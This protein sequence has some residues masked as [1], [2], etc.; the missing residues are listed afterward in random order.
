MTVSVDGPGTTING[1]VITAAP[2]AVIVGQSTYRLANSPATPAN[3]A[4]TMVTGGQIFTAMQSG[5]SIYIAQG[6]STATVAE[7]SSATLDGQTIVAGSN[8][9]TMGSSTATFSSMDA[10]ATSDSEE[11]IITGVSGQKFTA[12][13]VSGN[14]IAVADGVT[15][16]AGGAGAHIEGQSVSLASNNVVVDGTTHGLSYAASQ[17]SAAGFA[18]SGSEMTAAITSSSGSSV[19]SNSASSETSRRMTTTSSET[20]E[21]PLKA[22]TT[23]ASNSLSLQGRALGLATLILAMW[24]LRPWLA[25]LLFI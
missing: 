2:S 22:T 25:M 7:V 13:I 19:V 1:E 21:K 3:K 18:T 8:G 6:G 10:S 5:I 4:A 23:S 12:R 24:I 11:A 16:T 20:S 9:I 15:L 14:T 17:S